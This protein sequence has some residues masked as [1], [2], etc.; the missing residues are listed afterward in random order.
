MSNFKR[1]QAFDLTNL[2]VCEPALKHSEAHDVNPYGNVEFSHRVGFVCF[3]GFNTGFRRRCDF[4]IAVTPD[5]LARNFRFAFTQLNL[6]GFSGEPAFDETACH[7][8]GN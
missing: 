5:D 3:D 6:P 1:T 8:S 7:A 2:I 4:L